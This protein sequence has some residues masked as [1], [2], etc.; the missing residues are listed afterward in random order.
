MEDL[1]LRLLAVIGLLASDGS[2]GPAAL[3]ALTL[4]SYSTPSSRLSTRPLQSGPVSHALIH[5][6]APFSRFSITY[7]VIGDP[8]SFN[9]GVHRRST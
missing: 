1:R 9:G 8:P 2:P 3:M 4:N 5:L 7:P 6:G